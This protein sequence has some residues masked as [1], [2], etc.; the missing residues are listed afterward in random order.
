MLENWERTKKFLPI[1]QADVKAL[2][3]ANEEF[4]IHS[5]NCPNFLV[6][7]EN[8]AELVAITENSEDAQFDLQMALEDTIENWME[9]QGISLEEMD[10]TPTNL[11]NQLL[12]ISLKRA[13]EEYQN[14]H[15]TEEQLRTSLRAINNLGL[16]VPLE[17]S[18]F[19]VK[20]FNGLTKKDYQICQQLQKLGII[21]EDF[22]TNSR[23]MMLN[24]LFDEQNLPIPETLQ[25]FTKEQ[26]QYWNQLSDKIGADAF[27]IY[28]EQISSYTYKQQS[29]RIGRATPISP[30][31]F[32][33][34]NTQPTPIAFA[35]GGPLDQAIWQYSNYTQNPQEIQAFVGEFSDQ[36]S[37]THRFCFD[38]LTKI[39]R[40]QYPDLRNHFLSFS[41]LI[42]NPQT[43]QLNWFESTEGDQNLIPKEK[44]WQ[45][46]ASP[47][48]D[49]GIISLFPDYEAHCSEKRIIAAK[50]SDQLRMD[51]A[52]YI[53]DLNPFADDTI[54]T[55]L[56]EVTLEKDGSLDPRVFKMP[57]NLG[58]IK[59][60]RLIKNFPDQLPQYFNS[61]ELAYLNLPE[62][63]RIMLQDFAEKQADNQVDFDYHEL[64]EKVAQPDGPTDELFKLAFNEHRVDLLYG[65]PLIPVEDLPFSPNQHYII[66][67]YQEILKSDQERGAELG[68]EYL[69]AIA[70]VDLQDLTFE[71]IDSITSI[72]NRVTTSNAIELR[73]AGKDFLH[74]VAASQDPEAKLDQIEQVFLHNN[75]PYAGKVFR[76]FQILYPTNQ[77]F[78]KHFNYVVNRGTLKDLPD[79]GIISRESVLF[80]DLIKASIGSNNR[81][82]RQYIKSLRQ[83]QQLTEQLLA[84]DG[85]SYDNLDPSDQSIL[86]TYLEHIETLYN[87]TQKGRHEPYITSGDSKQDLIN[88][89]TNFNASERINL[90]DRV[91]RSFC[92]MLGIRSLDELEQYMDSTISSADAKNRARYERND[93]T[94]Q[95]NDLI[96]A[97]EAQYLDSILQNGAICKEFL[98]GEASSD[99]T[100]LD[101]DLTRLGDECTGDINSAM[102]WKNTHASFS[103]MAV[104][105][106][107]KN[108]DL[109][110]TDGTK[111]DPSKLE[112]WDNG[113]SNCGIR[114]GFPS[115]A[116]DFIV[117]DQSSVTP[118]SEARLPFIC[119]EIAKN[120]F[121]IPVVDKASGQCIFSPQDYD[122]LRRKLS[123]LERYG[124]P[125]FQFATDQDLYTPG[126]ET[127]IGLIGEQDTQIAAQRQAVEAELSNK[128]KHNIAG[129][130]GIKPTPDGDLTPGFVD[131][132]DT[133]S[134][135]RGTSIPG[136]KIDFDFIMRI[137]ASIY[138]NK[139]QRQGFSDTL[140]QSLKASED[141]SNL[142]GIRLDGV[143]ITGLKDPVKLD[144]SFTQ[145]TNHLEFSTDQALTERLNAIKQQSP[146]RHKAVIANII[147]SK[148]LLKNA[149]VY[150]PRHSSEELDPN[151]KG[152]LGGVGIENWIL[153]NGGSLK[154]AAE[155]FLAAA[156]QAE[157]NF[158]KFCEIY[159]IWDAG[160]NHFA[161]C[162]N[163]TSS[164]RRDS[165]GHT[166][167]Y[168]NFIT[169]NMDARGFSRMVTALR[170]YL[171][172]I[173]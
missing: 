161:V 138:N 150:K 47:E 147:L 44:F 145:R 84:Q 67:K 167:V 79:T 108:S 92:Y 53:L 52:N 168:D 48:Y 18:Y 69:H 95:A 13:A 27:S 25:N 87:Q 137:D 7:G 42:L 41:N 153:Q 73:R 121:Y 106:V 62:G 37:P 140:R 133:G 17:T 43:K 117:Y 154:V 59:R 75:L 50:C 63:Y 74:E 93:F 80:A 33:D 77:S 164:E 130:K 102:D 128:L 156:E 20:E 152:G 172:N 65:Q 173:T 157:Y 68:Q 51:L 57:D 76:S 123:G 21:N 118:H 151:R 158:N 132:I 10:E 23:Q 88:L 109:I 6:N 110:Q 16:K 5:P 91:V 160:Q 31:I 139:I 32:F 105:L 49:L 166:L 122:E 111:Y 165:F 101:A 56:L 1:F 141:K 124:A 66:Q 155:N 24:Q 4:N 36:L 98:N 64:I 2:L 170:Q 78:N 99:G 61:T 115:S 143:E 126:I 26:A 11:A 135:G 12:A 45:K 120:G 40:E 94:L 46:V 35:D 71:Q 119:S 28:Y 85:E 127:I 81:S 89:A 146:E 60:E 15:L 9:E 86:K 114:T 171:G 8:L 129:F 144:I 131:L 34:D 97:V 14:N 104:N 162:D 113:N 136:D 112:L 55:T 22:Q 148:Q 116:I 100:P 30:A 39:N 58:N 83:G 142:N 38:A 169:R 125:E 29:I 82:M 90:P 3:D 103:A 70:Q 72:V 149:D 54:T 159:Q 163:E 96:K 134:T 19:T 107:I